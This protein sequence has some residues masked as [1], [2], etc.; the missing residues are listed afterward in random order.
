MTAARDT[1]IEV[2]AESLGMNVSEVG[3]DT[4]LAVTSKWDSLAHMRLILALEARLHRRLTPEAI[5][6]IT[7]LRDV[8]SLIDACSRGR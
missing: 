7:N 4:A 8:I 5:V 1:A 2:L 3:D 6:S